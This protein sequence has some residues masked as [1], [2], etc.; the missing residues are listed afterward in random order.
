MR[1][2]AS[3][4][5]RTLVAASIASQLG[6]WAARLALSLLVFARTDDP[7]AVGLVA[8][9]LVLPWLGPGQWLA[10][11]GDRV[12]RRRLLM[13]CDIIRGASFLLIG[14]VELSLLPLVI[15]VTIAATADPVFEANRSALI[16]DLVPDDDYP[17]AIQV[18]GAI[19]QAAQLAGFA[20]GGLLAALLGASGALA[21]NGV[22]FLFS[23]LLL[24][25]IRTR[26]ETQRAGS[27]PKLSHAYRFLANDRVSLIA[28]ATTFVTVACAMAIESQ[29]VVYGGDIVDLSDAGTG[30]LAAVVPAATLLA[31]LDLN[32]EGSDHDVLEQGLIVAFMASIPAAFL[33]G[34]G[35]NQASAFVGFAMVGMVFTFSTSANIA[36]GRRIPSDIRAG[37]FGVLQALVFLATSLGTAAGGIFAQSIGSERAAAG[38]MV[39]TAAMAL[40]ATTALRCCSVDEPSFASS[41]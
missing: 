12:D 13:A 16:V 1:V 28:V 10:A 3:R 38:A 30:L 41:S 24:S 40:A 39:A 8:T 22:T 6:D 14:F 7:K 36:V 5:F 18:A 9:V 29:A 32:T 31:I 37:T 11:L 23:A 35:A 33:L 21:L 4:D 20:S 19:N 15:V 34:T 27:K 26:T 2:P 17:A 25:Q